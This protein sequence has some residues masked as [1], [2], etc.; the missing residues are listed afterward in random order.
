[1][2]Y[3]ADLFGFGWGVHVTY[4]YIII[5]RLIF[6]HFGKGFLLKGKRISIGAQTQLLIILSL[7]WI[8]SNIDRYTPWLLDNYLDS[9]WLEVVTARDQLIVGHSLHNHCDSSFIHL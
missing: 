7:S 5:E 2:W 6:H 1:L 8:Q 9:E 3:S 4:S